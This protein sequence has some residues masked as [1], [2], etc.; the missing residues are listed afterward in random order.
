MKLVKFT[1]IQPQE[2]VLITG[3]FLVA[4]LY[5]FTDFFVSEEIY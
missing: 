1:K 5:I 4:Y 2:D 3:A